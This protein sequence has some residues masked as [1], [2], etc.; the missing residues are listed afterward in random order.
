VASRAGARILTGPLAF[1]VGG[2]VDVGTL[3]ALLARE[4][5]RRHR[6]PEGG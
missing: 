3:L 2:L 6:K 5:L 1:L 4:R